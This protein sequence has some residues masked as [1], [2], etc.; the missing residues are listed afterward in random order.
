M[1]VKATITGVPETA[2][3]RDVDVGSYLCDSDQGLTFTV[4]AVPCPYCRRGLHM[5][6]EAT[7]RK[8]GRIRRVVRILGRTADGRP[9]VLTQYLPPRMR[10]LTCNSCRDQFAVPVLRLTRPPRS[11]SSSQD[12]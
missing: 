9:K 5:L 7:R 11:S 8:A 4:T 10:V 3:D 1:K 12:S 6:S 2:R